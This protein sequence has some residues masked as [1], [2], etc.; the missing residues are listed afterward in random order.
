MSFVYG[1]LAVAGWVWL[2]MVIAVI[3]ARWK[4]RGIRPEAVPANEKQ[5]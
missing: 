2:A 3:V 4:V 5:H 1:I